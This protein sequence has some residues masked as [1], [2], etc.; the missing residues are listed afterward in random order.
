MEAQ[1]DKV[2]GPRLGKAHDDVGRL[3]GQRAPRLGQR[4][5][6]PHAFLVGLVLQR[7]H[8]RHKARKNNHSSGDGTGS[9]VVVQ[10][11]ASSTGMR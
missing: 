1:P 8:A 9:R 5:R 7:G 11:D 2:V 10:I 4:A 6:Q 3:V